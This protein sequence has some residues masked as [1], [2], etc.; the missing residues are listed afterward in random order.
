M[1]NGA[2][3]QWRTGFHN[4]IALYIEE[5]AHNNDLPVISVDTKTTHDS[6]ISAILDQFL[7]R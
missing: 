5:S 4:M 7:L 6:V 1:N 3:E 2:Y